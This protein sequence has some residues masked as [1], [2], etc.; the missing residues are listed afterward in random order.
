MNHIDLLFRLRR[1]RTLTRRYG[2]IPCNFA[3]MISISDMQWSIV[4][5]QNFKFAACIWFDEHYPRQR[6]YI[7]KKKGNHIVNVRSN[8]LHLTNV[9]VQK[10]SNALYLT[11][12]NSTLLTFPCNVKNVLLI[13]SLRCSIFFQGYNKPIYHQLKEFF[14]LK[15]KPLETI[16]LMSSLS[17]QTYGGNHPCTCCSIC[18]KF[19]SLFILFQAT[20]ALH[21]LASVL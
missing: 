14:D 7:E 8:M 1:E 2:I 15:S 5:W 3:P 13:K 9:Y 6:V 21:T 12:T 17:H 16:F 19:I 10:M 4:S 20:N 18:I 11:F